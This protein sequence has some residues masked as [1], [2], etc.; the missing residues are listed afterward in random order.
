MAYRHSSRHVY[1]AL[2]CGF[3]CATIACSLRC[4]V[5]LLGDYHFWA[6]LTPS[7]D[8]ISGAGQ[9]PVDGTP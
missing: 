7:W 9:L 5:A 3:D 2:G 8:N 6:L 4:G 1:I